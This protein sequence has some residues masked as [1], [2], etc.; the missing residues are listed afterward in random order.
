MVMKRRGSRARIRE[1]GP[2]EVP[3]PLRLTHARKPKDPAGEQSPRREQQGCRAG[4][5]LAPWAP[6]EAE[7]LQ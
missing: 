3:L 5:A 2:E 4:T 6:E 7:Y 1:A